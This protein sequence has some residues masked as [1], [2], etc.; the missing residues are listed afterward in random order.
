MDCMTFQ[1]S[2]H[3]W[4]FSQYRMSLS[5]FIPLKEKKR[6]YEKWRGENKREKGR[7]EK[8]ET[9]RKRETEG[10]MPRKET[11]RKEDIRGENLKNNN[12][13]F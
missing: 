3:L 1:Y 8:T 7:G 9:E 6:R 5:S 11:R 13:K 12:N 4:L 10:A 2:C